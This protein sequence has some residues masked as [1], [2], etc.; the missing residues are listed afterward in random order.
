GAGGWETGR[1]RGASG[2]AD[3]RRAHQ[4]AYR[5]EPAQDDIPCA[6]TLSP[7]V[8]LTMVAIKGT[9]GRPCSTTRSAN[10]IDARPR[11]P[12]QPTYATLGGARP[13]PTIASATGAI[14]MIVRLH[15]A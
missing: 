14:L 9:P 2:S 4:A 11:G 12:N 7:T 6:S 13:V 1:P 15:R 3:S 8:M 5:S 10:T